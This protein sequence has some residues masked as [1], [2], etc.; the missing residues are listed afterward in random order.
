MT[1]LALV[2]LAVAN[3][4]GRTL[5]VEGKLRGDRVTIEAFF[6]DN[7]PAAQAQITV[8]DKSKRPVASGTTLGK[9]LAA[10]ADRFGDRKAEVKR[11]SLLSGI[12]SMFEGAMHKG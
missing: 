4:D 7:T 10:M 12:F 1:M 2:L 8:V 3:G 6:D 5:H 9:T 11:P